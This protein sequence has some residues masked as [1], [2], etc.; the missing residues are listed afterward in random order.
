MNELSKTFEAPSIEVIILDTKP[1][2]Q[3]SANEILSFLFFKSWM[4]FFTILDIRNNK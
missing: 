3:D 1:P 4:V 2:V